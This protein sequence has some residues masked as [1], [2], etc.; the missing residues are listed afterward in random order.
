[1]A[2]LSVKQKTKSTTNK[3]EVIYTPWHVAKQRIQIRCDR[4]AG[5][6]ETD[7][8]EAEESW[9]GG[10]GHAPRP[11]PLARGRGLI[12]NMESAANIT[13]REMRRRVLL[14]YM[15]A[16]ISRE[17]S[18]GRP[19]GWRKSFH[20]NNDKGSIRLSDFGKET[21]TEKEAIQLGL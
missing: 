15:R 12:N 3:Q 14:A 9:R 2:A 4:E 1:M 13:R 8:R 17:C 19:N 16:G 5:R 21:E 10:A 6:R 11:R 18:E 20:T 7:S